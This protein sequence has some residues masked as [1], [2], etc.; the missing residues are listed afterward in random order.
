M[1]YCIGALSEIKDSLSAEVGPFENLVK[2]FSYEG[3]KPKLKAFKENLKEF[4]H[5]SIGRAKEFVLA[6]KEHLSSQ[7]EA[8]IKNVKE[9]GAKITKSLRESENNLLNEVNEKLNQLKKSCFQEFAKSI[10]L[11]HETNPATREV[12]DAV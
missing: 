6:V 9:S 2:D 12:T 10:K 7:V 3:Y 1:I 11:L 4:D 5:K 8:N